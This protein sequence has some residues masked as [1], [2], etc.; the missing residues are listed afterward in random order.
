MAPLAINPIPN[1]ESRSSEIGKFLIRSGRTFGCRNCLQSVPMHTR[2]ADAQQDRQRTP[3]ETQD[4]ENPQSQSVPARILETRS[5]V[6][7]GFSNQQ[8]HDEKTDL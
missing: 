7:V 3:E 4:G 8:V 5:G 1:L 6:I 2:F